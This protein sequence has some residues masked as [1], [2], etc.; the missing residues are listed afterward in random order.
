MQH[1]SPQPLEV[2]IYHPQSW[3]T[4]GEYSNLQPECDPNNHHIQHLV[5]GIGQG[6]DDSGFN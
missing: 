3:E 1:E 5:Y 4:M 6:S 2:Q